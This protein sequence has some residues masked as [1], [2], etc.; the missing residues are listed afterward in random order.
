MA[1]DAKISFMNQTEKKLATEIT[2]EAMARVMSIVADVLEGYEMRE[3]ITTLEPNEDLLQCYLDAL[4]VEG[5]S[6]KTIARY[7][8]VIERMMKAVG[9]PTRR[10]TVYHLRNYLSVQQA[11]GI[12]DSTTE[13]I[14][15]V[16]SAY[17]N[18]LQRESLIDKNPTA[19]LGTIKCAKKK[20]KVLTD[21]DLYKLKSHCENARDRAIVMFLAAT[22]CRI[23][24]VTSLNRED[25]DFFGMKC[26]V[27][28]KG[29]KE[30][31][32]FFDAVTTAALRAYM[33]E[34][35]D[36]DPALFVSRLKRRYENNGIRVMLKELAKKAGVEHVHPHKF[37]RTLAT[38]LARHGMP[39]QEVAY[40]LGHDKIDTTMK[41]VIQ[42][43]DD[44]K[45][46]YRRY[47]V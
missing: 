34:R 22:G 9:I 39:I 43:D 16:L 15:Q 40:I 11:R 19:N 25:I 45:N 20:K 10:I 27:H 6:E 26:V 38:E 3:T 17:F 32:V 23:S 36:S 33:A 44:V 31:T 46:S 29:N 5:R 42:N 41:Y 7:R 35:T 21:V 12:A 37:R 1:I 47:A 18:W 8:Y 14:R 4:K 28:G 30:R 13:G 2:A 24:E